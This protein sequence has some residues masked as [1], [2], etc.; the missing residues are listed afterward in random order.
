VTRWVLSFD[1][2]GTGHCL[3]TEA[4]DLP[5]IGRLELV[6]AST[7]EFNGTRQRWEVRG[8]VNQLLF[9]DPSRRACLEW[10]QHHYNQ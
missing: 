2:T 9:S 6:R 7:I 10:E 4:V 5:A 3:Y 1:A 8:S